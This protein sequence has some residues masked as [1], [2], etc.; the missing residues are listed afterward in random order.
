VISGGW[1]WAGAG[2]IWSLAGGTK[3]GSGG[4]LARWWPGWQGRSRV[5]RHAVCHRAS[6]PRRRATPAGRLGARLLGAGSREH[7]VQCKCSADGGS[8]TRGCGLAGG[9]RPAGWPGGWGLT[10]RERR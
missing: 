9:M 5:R 4:A 8:A 2:G 3:L 7:E 10:K 1:P 6:A